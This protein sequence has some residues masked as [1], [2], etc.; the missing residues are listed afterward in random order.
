MTLTFLA[1]R[2]GIAVLLLVIGIGLLAN[3]LLYWVGPQ[4]AAQARIGEEVDVVPLTGWLT[5]VYGGEATIYARIGSDGKV[6]IGYYEIVP[7]GIPPSFADETDATV[8][9][10]ISTGTWDQGAQAP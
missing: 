2:K 10:S 3:A 5:G 9:H 8:Y 4:V 6:A 1:S 7:P